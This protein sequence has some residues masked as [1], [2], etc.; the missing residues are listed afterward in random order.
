MTSFFK[1]QKLVK[2][3]LLSFCILSANILHAQVPVISSFVPANATVGTAVT[4]SGTNFNTTTTNNIVFFGA[5]RATVQSA[6]STQIVVIVP[7][8]AS[9]SPISVTANNATAYSRNVFILSF[10]GGGPIV[11]TA[12][13]K[14][15][16]IEV[17]LG[18]STKIKDLDGDGKPDLIVPV[19][20]DGVLNIFR[21]INNTPGTFSSNSLASKVTL[22]LVGQPV[23]P[24]Y[25]DID[26][27]GKPDIIYTI[28]DPTNSIN[29]L[30]NNSTPGNISFAANVQIPLANSAG[31]LKIADMNNDGKPDIINYNSKSFSILLNTSTVSAITFAAPTDFAFTETLFD[32]TPADFD[33]DGKTDL[34]VSVSAAN[35]QSTISFFKNTSTANALSFAPKVD[36]TANDVVGITAAD[37]DGDGQPDIVFPEQG[38]FCVLNN[39]STPGSIVFNKVSFT[40][41][42]NLSYIGALGDFDGDGKLDIIGGTKTGTL[43]I[44]KNTSTYGAVSFAKGVIFNVPSVTDYGD[45]DSDGKPDV[46]GFASGYNLNNMIVVRNKV[47]EPILSAVTPEIA[48]EGATVSITGLNFTGATEVAFGGVKAASF[49]VNSATSITA[50]LGKGATGAVTV[51]NP[52]STATGLN[53]MYGINPPAI[54]SFAPLTGPIGTTVTIS[55]SGFNATPANNIVYFGVARATVASATETQLVVKVP[56][57]ANYQPVTVTTNGFI[58]ASTKSFDVTFTNTGVFTANSFSKRLDILSPGGPMELFVADFD[59]DGKPDVV[60]RATS[61]ISIFRN[62]STIGNTSFATRQDITPGGT[63]DKIFVADI[64]A[65]GKPDLLYGDITKLTLVILKNKSTAGSIVFDTPLVITD[66]SAP[67]GITV[68]DLDG[69]GRPDVAVSHEN[70]VTFSVFRNTTQNDV[71]SFDAAVTI[72]LTERDHAIGIYSSDMDGDGKTDLVTSQEVF[73]NISTVGKLA[74]TSVKTFQGG[75]LPYGQSLLI[76]DIDGDNKP[77]LLTSYGNSFFTISK[78]AT[79]NGGSVAFNSEQRIDFPTAYNS[80]NPRSAGFSM[81][82]LDGDGKPDLVVAD[83]K[84]PGY[85]GVYKNNSTPGAIALSAKNGYTNGE[86]QDGWIGTGFSGSGVADFDGDGR[87]DIV[88][89]TYMGASISISTN[90]IDMPMI[91]SFTPTLAGADQTVTITGANF[92]NAAV[93]KMGGVAAKSFTVTSSTT[94]SAVVGQGASGDIAVTTPIGTTTIKGFTYLTAPVITSFRPQAAGPGTTV[95][96]TGTG[97]TSTTTVAF[98][99]VPTSGFIVSPTTIYAGIVTGASGD[100]SVTNAVGTAKA[101][102]FIFVPTPVITANGPTTFNLG[103]SVILTTSN[104]AGY[105]YIWQRNGVMVS[106]NSNSS[107]YTVKQSGSYSVYV[108]AFGV[109]ITSNLI[110]VTVNFV[111][112]VDNFKIAINSV[113]CKGEKDGSIV[114]NAAQAFDYSAFLIDPRGTGSNTSFKTTG[115]FDNLTPGTYQV[116]VTV[117]GNSDYKQCFTAV[118]T[119]PKDIKLFSVIQQN[120]DQAVLALEGADKYYIRLNGIEQVT[121]NNQVTLALNNGVNHITVNS[122]KPCQGIIAQ[123]LVIANRVVPFPNPFEN[124]IYLNLGEKTIKETRVR[125]YDTFNKLVYNQTFTN[126]SGILKLDVPSLKLGVYFLHMDAGDQSFNFKMTRK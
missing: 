47:N 102:G 50:I 54:T 24:I 61:K 23:T 32:V 9:C 85:L 31:G 29:V 12:F 71:V 7:A 64:N 82:D 18:G 84:I 38:R 81:G 77:D 73:K 27:D 120:S 118:V 51:K 46:V 33:G 111:I 116:C 88:I 76:G 69:D 70:A 101:A 123:D 99:G 60:D 104:V 26:S 109:D 19:R 119:E 72:P 15:V 87:P 66:R 62:T 48:Q 28:S 121:T 89:S 79:V 20:F 86:P 112:P 44:A 25:E 21:N 14:E 68:A 100:I 56:L 125:L 49:T 67:N 35:N 83:S 106:D 96:I 4:I 59:G 58:A 13:D 1:I 90:T 43:M 93:V 36:Y 63:A 103:S 3:F 22:S 57:G 75:N 11:S 41:Q 122:D 55:G 30:K 105:Q 16:D 94:I 115:R 34:A 65:D 108:K 124:V 113:T 110:N 10:G 53:I 6:T 74:F 78:N 40:D 114:I 126:R 80:E 117:D 17:P 92:D 107:T 39:K 42:V 45:I 5:V 8:G 91:S 2:Y 98:G 95:E 37:M 52:Y 97:F